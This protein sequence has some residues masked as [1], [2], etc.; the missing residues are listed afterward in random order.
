MELD[1]ER[2]CQKFKTHRQ[3]EINLSVIDVA[4]DLRGHG[5]SD[6]PRGPYRIAD[7]LVDPDCPS[8]T[9]TD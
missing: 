2:F 3:S 4:P 7:V 1:L 6:K 9:A 8:L 5:Q